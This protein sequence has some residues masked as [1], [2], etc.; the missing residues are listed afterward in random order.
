VVCVVVPVMCLVTPLWPLD[1]KPTYSRKAPPV[2]KSFARVVWS[3]VVAVYGI[4][5]G[6]LTALTA[7]TAAWAYL[8]TTYTYT[9]LF[10]KVWSLW[11][12]GASRHQEAPSE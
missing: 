3:G 5:T 10:E 7:L 8:I 9:L 6:V 4:V 12:E 2:S 1:G 11:S